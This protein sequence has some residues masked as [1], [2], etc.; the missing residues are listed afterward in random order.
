MKLFSAL[1]VKLAVL[2]VIKALTKF[3]AQAF[4][5]NF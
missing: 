2:E 3:I 4:S 1:A 5:L